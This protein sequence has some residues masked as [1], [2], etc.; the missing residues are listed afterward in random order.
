M[1]LNNIATN[2]FTTEETPRTF[3]LYSLGVEQH[4][5][6]GIYLTHAD[7]QRC[8]IEV[9]SENEVQYLCPEFAG[10]D[11]EENAAKMKGV[12]DNGVWT[13]F[14]SYNNEPFAECA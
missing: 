4:Q 5:L 11:E 3:T 10:T 14:Y 1:S 7:I 6:D 8:K 12:F 2:F 9:I 13:L